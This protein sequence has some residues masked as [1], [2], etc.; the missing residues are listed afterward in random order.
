MLNTF[1]PQ[2]DPQSPIQKFKGLRVENPVLK[3][4]QSD[5]SGTSLMRTDKSDSEKIK[6]SSLESSNVD[7]RLSAKDTSDSDPTSKDG[8]ELNTNNMA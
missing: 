4:S 8:Q 3:H 7:Q 6:L 2:S 1:K 5:Q